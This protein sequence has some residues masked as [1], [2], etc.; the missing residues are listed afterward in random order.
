MDTLLKLMACFLC[1]FPFV[2]VF[3]TENFLLINGAENEVILEMGPQINEEFTPCSTFKIV[4]SL[5]GYDAE[6]LKNE[7]TP[8]W[9]FQEGYDDYLEVWKM[10]QTPHSWMKNSCVWFSQVLALQL[11]SEKI[12]SYLASLEY[13]NQD[14]SGGLAKA[15]VGSS[16]KISPRDQVRFIQKMIQGELAVSSHAVQMT[17]ELLLLDTLPGGWKLF[18][19]TGWSGSMIDSD[20]KNIEIGWF[21][22]WIEKDHNF[23]PFAYNIRE[24]KINLAQRI[25]RAKQLLVES[26][27]INEI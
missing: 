15:W 17:K 7:K 26:Q 23:F 14:I 27:I 12:Q 1:V 4:L 2:N 18:G 3:S 5:M 6:I 19:K 9:D 16:L 24:G 11:G 22:G 21:V 25:P 10:P 13:G 20:G 8:V